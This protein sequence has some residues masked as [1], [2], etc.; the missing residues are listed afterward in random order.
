VANKGR[1]GMKPRVKWVSK[2]VKCV[3]CEGAGLVRVGEHV[4]QITC[5][6]CLGALWEDPCG[7]CYGK[8]TVPAGTVQDHA[9]CPECEGKGYVAVKAKETPAPAPL[10]GESA[11]LIAAEAETTGGEDAAN[12]DERA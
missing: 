2:R 6:V 7:N 11:P 10:G 9:K 4:Q 1:A 3:R 12:D 5:P 8:G